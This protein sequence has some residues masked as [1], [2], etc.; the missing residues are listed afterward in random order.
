MQNIPRVILPNMSI[1]HDNDEN[2]RY[3]FSKVL[4]SAPV[5]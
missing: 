3:S 2:I 5:V 4:D 1:S